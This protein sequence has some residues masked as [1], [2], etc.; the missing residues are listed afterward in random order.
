MGGEQGRGPGRGLR[1]GRGYGVGSRQLCGLCQAQGTQR[2]ARGTRHSIS[3]RRMAGTVAGPHV[4]GGPLVVDRV[5]ASLCEK[6][7]I[8]PRTRDG[9]SPSGPSV[10]LSAALGGYFEPSPIWFHKKGFEGTWL[11]LVRELVL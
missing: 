1:A 9:G 8:S 11:K 10:H 5:P 4:F 6:A 2:E 7:K 3:A